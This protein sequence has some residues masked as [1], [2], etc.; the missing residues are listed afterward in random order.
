M[1]RSTNNTKQ[2]KTKEE[3]RYENE[4]IKRKYFDYLKQ[5]KGFSQSSIVTYEGAILQWQDFTKGID[6]RLF[7]KKR[8]VEFKDFLATRKS[9]RGDTISIS[10]Q[11]HTLRKLR[12]FFDWLSRQEGYRQAIQETDIG[13]L[14]LG[15]K[16]S[17]Q[18]LQSKRR[19]IPTME[20]V[21]KV[22]EAIEPK[23][24]ID[25]RDRALLSLTLL[26]GAR[27]S[28]IVSL[29]L[30]SFDPVDMVIDQDP[31]LGVKTKFSKRIATALFPLDYKEPK[32]Y[33]I[34][35]YEYLKNERGFKENDPLFP[36][37]KVENGKENIS[38]YSTGEVEPIYWSGSSPARKIF[39]KRFK[40]VGEPYYNP[41][42]LRHLLVKEFMKKP[43][44]E[45]QKKA[46]SQNLGHESVT[47]TFGSYGYG[48]IDESRQI[49]LM[50]EIE[51]VQNGAREV[52]YNISAEELQ[53]LLHKA[54]SEKDA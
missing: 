38:Y 48:Q 45:E 18:A 8:A 37:T 47:T 42:S 16:E 27:I 23:T 14:S 28:A 26:T 39:E 34:D 10:F 32:Q 33:F 15:K 20:Q 1:S 36:A 7:S 4:I 13:Y 25:M 12:G 21:K 40:A 17:R 44:T 50:R 2:T 11:Y 29:P 19:K 3:V 6:F 35:W 53:A 54:A 43:L 9:K 24:E 31:N 30:G 49:E 52:R 5:S 46:I 51:A 22:I 41:H